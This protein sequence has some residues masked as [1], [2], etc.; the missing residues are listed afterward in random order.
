[1]DTRPSQDACLGVLA[2]LGLLPMI[3]VAPAELPKQ[4]VGDNIWMVQQFG[5]HRSG[6]LF[7]KHD[8]QLIWRAFKSST[9]LS[10][11]VIP[12][13]KVWT[14]I[15]DRRTPRKC[16]KVLIPAIFIETPFPQLSAISL[17]QSSIG[18]LASA[19]AQTVTTQGIVCPK[20]SEILWHH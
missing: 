10:E 3:G 13:V 19:E 4:I 18:R 14:K 5:D 20:D 6:K 15:C 11:E 2:Q 1:M 7:L 12:C 9:K 17:R 8:Y 16:F